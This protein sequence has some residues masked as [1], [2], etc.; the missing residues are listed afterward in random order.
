M[1]TISSRVLPAMVGGLPRPSLP[2]P[3]LS[4][5]SLSRASLSRRCIAAAVLTLVAALGGFGLMTSAVR[6]PD[7]SAVHLQVAATALARAAHTVDGPGDA[8]GRS[9][10]QERASCWRHAHRLGQDPSTCGATP[11]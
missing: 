2:R 4:R 10:L 8:G 5:A 6:L 9:A 3:S 7:L 11:R 1:T